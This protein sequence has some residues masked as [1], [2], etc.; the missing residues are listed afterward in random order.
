MIIDNL[1]LD[2]L[3]HIRVSFLD[4]NGELPERSGLNWGKRP[5]RNPNQAYI[6]LTSDIYR[7]DFFPDIGTRFTVHTDDN[8]VLVCTRAQDNGKAIHTPRDNSIMGRYFRNRLNLTSGAL[9]EK[10]HLVQYGRTYVDFYKI[11]GKTYYMDFSQ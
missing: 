7:T 9:V 1:V 11:D 4:S 8:E 6:K 3:P 2:E 10:E 5:D